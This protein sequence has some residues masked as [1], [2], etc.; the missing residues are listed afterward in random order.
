M[1]TTVARWLIDH[2]P[3]ATR[4]CFERLR[5]GSGCTCNEC[6][7]FDAAAGRTFPEDFTALCRLLEINPT[8]PS[9]L[10]YCCGDASGRHQ[11][12]GWFHFVGSIVAGDDV[13]KWVG[14]PGTYQ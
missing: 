14:N 2:D 12:N 13:I 10:A 7:N 8:K 6:R 11:T 1:Q 3:S 4:Q 5:D 9:E